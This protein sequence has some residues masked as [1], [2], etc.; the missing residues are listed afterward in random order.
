MKCQYCG[1]DYEEAEYGH[2]CKSCYAPA[3]KR[4]RFQTSPHF[5]DGTEIRRDYSVI[6]VGS[7]GGG[8]SGFSCSG[9]S[10]GLGLPAQQSI[11]DYVAGGGV[12]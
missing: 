1:N 10:S 3:P 11:K 8:G 4:S 5:E 9:G 6:M 2:Y 7:G 12:K